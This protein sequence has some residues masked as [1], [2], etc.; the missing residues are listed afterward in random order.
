MLSIRTILHPT[1]FSDFSKYAFQLASALARDHRARLIVAHV[2]SEPTSVSTAAEKYVDYMDVKEKLEQI[3]A[4]SKI[5]LQHRL[6]AGDPVEEI[7]WLAKE[8]RTRLIVM[9]THGRSGLSRLLVGSVAEQVIRHAPCPVLTV[10]TPLRIV[11]R[12]RVGTGRATRRYQAGS[13]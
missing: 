11:R 3:Q 10:K 9:G 12:K 8:T 1:D 2:V 6:L 4:R 7:C 5:R 13:A